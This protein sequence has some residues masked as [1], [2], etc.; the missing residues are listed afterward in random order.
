MSGRLLRGLA[1]ILASNVPKSRY[2]IKMKAFS[3][4][5][6]ISLFNCRTKLVESANPRRNHDIFCCTRHRTLRANRGSVQADQ[7]RD[8]PVLVD[9]RVIPAPTRI[10]HVVRYGVC[11]LAVVVVCVSSRTVRLAEQIFQE[12]HVIRGVYVH[13]FSRTRR[14]S[15]RVLW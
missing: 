10:A 8:V 9:T 11:T 3:L 15:P 5:T 6:I 13:R 12:P 2:S 1:Y 7:P 14:T 4:P